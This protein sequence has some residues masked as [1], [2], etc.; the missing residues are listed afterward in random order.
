M[1]TALPFQSQCLHF[2]HSFLSHHVIK[3]KTF[4]P[5]NN[6]P[7]IPSEGSILRRKRFSSRSVFSRKTKK[8]GSGS[9]RLARL[10]LKLVPI[11]A[12]NLNASPRPLQLIAEELGGGDGSGGGLGFRGGSG[13]GWF[14]GRRRGGAR[15]LGFWVI[16]VVGGL[17]LMFVREME[18]LAVCRILGLGLSALGL[19][20]G[21]SK[22]KGPTVVKN[23]I[24]GICFLGA[25]SFWGLR[26]EEVL[27]RRS[28]VQGLSK[29][30][31]RRRRRPGK[32]W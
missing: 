7:I 4:F 18:S 17:S 32:F 14:D 13:W 10:V 29:S 19:I 1:Q 9:Q 11:I 23:W 8:K 16:L 15:K 28:W 2:R 25:V 3:S 30:L 22:K 5:S 21:W 27:Q 20:E 31:R 24:L 26:K 12:S 6:L